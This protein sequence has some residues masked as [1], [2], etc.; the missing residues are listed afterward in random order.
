MKSKVIALLAGTAL[1]VAAFSAFG[2][3]KTDCTD[4]GCCVAESCSMDCCDLF[5]C[6]AKA[7]K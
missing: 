5:S 7:E 6:S 1:M 2:S 3:T 4:K